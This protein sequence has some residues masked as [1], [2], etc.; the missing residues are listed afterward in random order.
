LVFFE[1]EKILREFYNSS[2]FNPFRG[3]KANILNEKLTIL[4][5]ADIIRKATNSS[6]ITLCT[7]IFGRG[8][9]FYCTKK[10]E[11]AGGIHVIQTFFTE[12][13]SEEI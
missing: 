3:P 4:E 13:Y 10:V 2:H 6:Y 8:T 5:K 7:C 11:T 12:D 9:D 1:N